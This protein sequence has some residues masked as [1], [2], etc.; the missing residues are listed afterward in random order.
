MN[1]LLAMFNKLSYLSQAIIKRSSS[2]L[3]LQTQ[4]NLSSSFAPSESSSSSCFSALT[5]SLSWPTDT[6]PPGMTDV[7]RDRDAAFFTGGGFIGLETLAVAA[8]ATFLLLAAALG[9]GFVAVE[10]EA[11]AGIDLVFVAAGCNRRQ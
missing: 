3:V 4:Y 1:K 5:A 9:L 8:A 2:Y 10:V 6:L 11:G 7:E